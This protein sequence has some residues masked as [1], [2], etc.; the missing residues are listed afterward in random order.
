MVRKKRDLKRVATPMSTIDVN[1]KGCLKGVGVALTAAEKQVMHLYLIEHKTQAQIAKQRNTTRQAV[2]KIIRNLKK[3]G[4][5]GIGLPPHMGQQGGNLHFQWKDGWIRLHAQRFRIRII[6]KGRSY[7][8]ILEKKG[9]QD[10]VDGN[11]VILHRDSIIIY[12]GRFFYGRT[13]TQAHA[14]SVPYWDAFFRRLEHK[15]NVLIWKPGTINIKEFAYQYARMEDGIAK[16]V[17]AQKVR[18]VK[19]RATEDGKVWLITDKSFRVDEL[20]TIHPETAREDMD[21]AILPYVNDFR[22]KKPL[23]NSELEGLLKSAVVV[24][25][26]IAV[27]L[28]ACISVTKGNSGVLQGVALAVKA[29]SDC[30]NFLLEEKKKGLQQSKQLNIPEGRPEYV[31]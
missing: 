18:P 19:A 24:N 15:Y 12:S 28:N 5:F 25:K 31:G 22:D 20:E 3:K 16:I 27:G 17:N 11:S 6:N 26:D 13:G 10:H 2:S 1:F 21:E 9:N 29:N 23:R 30:I 4:A 7:K 14:E 8:K